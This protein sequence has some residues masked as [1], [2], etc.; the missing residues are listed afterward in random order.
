MAACDSG[1]QEQRR[2]MLHPQPL[3]SVIAIGKPDPVGA[4]QYPCVDPATARGTAFDFDRRI[5]SAQLIEQQVNAG[6][7]VRVGDGQKPVV[8]PFDVVHCVAGQDRADPFKKVIAYLR[9]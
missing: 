3:D 5:C 7:L 2:V 8:I 4:R 6:G 9:Q 1:G